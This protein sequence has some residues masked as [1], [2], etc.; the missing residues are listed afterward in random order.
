[1]FCVHNEPWSHL[2]SMVC[3]SSHSMCHV[4]PV[5][6]GGHHTSASCTSSHFGCS[7]SPVSL[8][9]HYMNNVKIY[10]FPDLLFPQW[11]LGA[12]S[13]QSHVHLAVQCIMCP[14][15]AP[16]ATM[17]QND[18]HLPVSEV[19]GPWWAIEATIWTT[20]RSIHFQTFFVPNEPWGPLY[21]NV[22]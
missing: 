14:H 12:T 2:I 5:S 13:N 3:I 1:M 10:P 9:S 6:P 16:G 21:I 8:G 11:A 20:S 15:W 22:M 17:L 4:S 19:L 7:G 18:L